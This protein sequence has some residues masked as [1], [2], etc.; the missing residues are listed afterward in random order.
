MGYIN[1]PVA[2]TPSWKSPVDT[3]ASLPASGNTL[4][5][6]RAVDDTGIIY[7]WTGA[8]WT[9]PSGSGTVTSVDM[10]VPSI[11]S[12][13]GNPITGAGTLAVTLATEVKNKV[14]VGP[15]TGSDATPTFR[16]LVGADLPLPQSAALGGVFSKAVVSNNFL[17][18]ISAVDGS[19]SQAQPAFTNISGTVAASQLPVPAA[20]ALGGVFSKAVVSNNFLTGISSV[21]GSVSQA[22][23]A[24]TNISGTIAAA[25]LPV[26]QAAALGAVFSKAAVSNNF[27]TSISSAD[28]SIGQAQP[29]F[30]NISGTCVLTTQVSGIL[31][32]ANGGTGN[33][34]AALSGPASST[35]TFTLP[36]ASDTI[37]C[38]GQVNAFT[39][40]QSITPVALTPG[41]TV[42]WNMNTAPNA[43]LTPAQNFTLSNPTNAVAG[44]S[45]MLTITQDGTGTRVITWGSNYRFAGGTKFVLSTAASS[46][47]EL[48]WYCPDGTHIDV[49]GLG[50]FA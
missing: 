15:A 26:A 49:S 16:L 46:V 43:T 9:A 45:G 1:L 6:A 21:D 11:L 47:D 7:V 5:D 22:Q 2:G 50:A 12:V 33:G 14:F 28:G 37:A 17:T 32:A 29:A 39:A 10:T 48:A 3:A 42:S 44:G 25:Q 38:L 24:F 41:T 23:P 4:G 35:K 27:L 8:A 19:V 30:T 20:A 13:S 31:P 36:N 18:G 40:Q 34:F